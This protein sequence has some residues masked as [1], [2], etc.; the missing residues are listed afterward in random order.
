[1]PP[2][3]ERFITVYMV[4]GG[5]RPDMLIPRILRNELKYANI[6]FGRDFIHVYDVVSAIE[7]YVKS[8]HMTGLAD[9]GTG[10]SVKVLDI[11][12]H[13]DSDVEE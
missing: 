4:S 7:V 9:V 10:Q 8:P 6:N 3:H 2:Y 12:D 5:L 13:F 11:I 1:M